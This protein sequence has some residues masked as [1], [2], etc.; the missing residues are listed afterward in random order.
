MINVPKSFQDYDD[1]DPEF[2][3]RQARWDYYETLKK[4]RKESTEDGRNFDADE[5][6]VWIEEKYGFK[7]VLNDT[8]ITDDYTVTDEQ[9]YLIFRLKYD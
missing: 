2:E 3:K 7:L 5:F 8:G 6:I 1:D 4:L 9:K